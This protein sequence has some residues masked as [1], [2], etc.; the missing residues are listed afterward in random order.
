MLWPDT[1]GKFLTVGN[2]LFLAVM[3]VIGLLLM[4][5]LYLSGPYL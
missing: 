5:L 3:A 4:A 2:V 1:H